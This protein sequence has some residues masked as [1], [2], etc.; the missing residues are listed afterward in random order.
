MTNRGRAGIS[1]HPGCFNAVASTGIVRRRLPVAAKIALATAGTMAEVPASP[2][3][4][5]GSKFLHNVDVDGRRLVHAQHLIGIEIAL[6]E[7]DAVVI[8]VLCAVLQPILIAVQWP[9][10]SV[11]GLACRALFLQIRRNRLLLQVEREICQSPHSSVL[12]A[13]PTNQ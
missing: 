10:L 6:N 1:L 4:P 8:A 2:I 3:P 11:P 5:G 7:Q 12:A 9:S 13:S